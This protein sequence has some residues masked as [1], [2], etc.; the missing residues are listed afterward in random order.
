MEYPYRAR[1]KIE[2]FIVEEKVGK[3]E[4]KTI[5]KPYGVV[6]GEII[7][8]EKNIYPMLERGDISFIAELKNGRI[9]S[10]EECCAMSLEAYK[11]ATIDSEEDST[12]EDD[13][14]DW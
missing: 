3:W 13:G 7:H 9:V 12:E 5:F 10:G 14:L 6:E 1:V 4:I 8:L 2:Y 11:N